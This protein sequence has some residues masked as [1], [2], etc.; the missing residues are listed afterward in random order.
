M[1]ELIDSAPARRP[2]PARPRPD[3]R[4]LDLRRPL[5][6]RLRGDRAGRDA[7]PAGRL[8]AVRRRRDRR[9]RGARIRHR[10]V[11]LLA[12]AIAGDAVNYAIGRAAGTRIIQKSRT[13]PTLAALDQPGLHRPGPR[14]LR[15]ARRQ[16]GRARPVHADR[17]D[18]RPVR[19]R[20]GRD[21]VSVVRLLQR[22]GRGRVG[23]ALPG[24][25]LSVRQRAG[26]QG[27]FL[28]GGARHRLRVGAADGHRVPAST[29][30][31]RLSP[32][33]VQVRRAA[34][35]R[36][37]DQ[38]LGQL[39]RVQLAETPFDAVTFATRPS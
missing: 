19:G 28:A 3:L 27:E 20:R 36:R 24:G 18:L 37:E 21:V 22:H 13:D 34:V 6:H 35:A 25:R 15:A 38:Q 9:H 5:R 30:P 14:V 1:T 29:G 10:G 4:R 17:P 8:A 39:V 7:V 12:A 2:P 26:H 23:R 32:D 33:P 31:G 16:G 11:L